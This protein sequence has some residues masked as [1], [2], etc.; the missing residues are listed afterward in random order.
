[1][2]DH[3]VTGAEAQY[4]LSNP[5]FVPPAASGGPRG[6][7]DWLRNSVARFS[8]GAA[9]ERRR[10]L[11][12]QALEGMDCGWLRQRVRTFAPAEITPDIARE[13]PIRILAEA[14]GV[15]EVDVSAVRTVAAAYLVG[16][17]GAEIDLAV[18]KLVGAFGGVADE[19]TAARIGL[20]VQACEATAALILSAVGTGVESALQS[21]P[22]ARS[23]TRL[24][25]TA[26]DI[27]GVPVAPGELL[28]VELS[29]TPFGAGAHACP[30][31]EQA[32][33]IATGVCE[34]L[35]DLPPRH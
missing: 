30:G 12:V 29:G 5:D 9:H 16:T 17:T 11:V 33:A 2:A 35:G 14:L 15:P 28:R 13:V 6:G 24:A 4:V 23:T 20:L 8:A 7:I 32:V 26:I 21:D 22:P 1:M 34:A 10:R 19:E 31:R 3:V 18:A 25:T 27:N